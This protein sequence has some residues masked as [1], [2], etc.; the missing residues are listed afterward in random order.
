[1]IY[2]FVHVEITNEPYGASYYVDTIIPKRCFFIRLKFGFKV[3]HKVNVMFNKIVEDMVKNGE[4]DEMSHYPSLRK[5]GL[6]ADFKFILINSR[7]TDD[8]NLSAY[9]QFIIK[10]YRLIKKISLSTAADFGLDVTNME[11]EMVPIKIAPSSVI[12]LE[13]VK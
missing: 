10:G 1:D 8:D 11:E 7:V 9:E 13:R 5:Y 6:P 12:E 2:W 4:V 3:E